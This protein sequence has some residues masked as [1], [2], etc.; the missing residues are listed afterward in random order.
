MP[1]AAPSPTNVER[2]KQTYARWSASGGRDADAWLSLFSDEG[3]LRSVGAEGAALSFA[4]AR[5]GRSGA[6]A[7]F[8]QLAEAWQIE[9]W[10][11]VTFVGDGDR[12]AVL[13][14]VGAKSRATGRSVEIDIAHFWRFEGGRA[15]E[16]TEIFDS[17]RAVAAATP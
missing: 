11:P 7:Y 5:H 4:G 15:V 9:H 17:A 8:A 13:G 14:R 1:D 12:I 3:V 2:L 16:C 6:E 10:T